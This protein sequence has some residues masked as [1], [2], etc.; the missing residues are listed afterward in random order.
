MGGGGVGLTGQRVRGVDRD[1]NRSG[2]VKRAGRGRGLHLGR[3]PLLAIQQAG[4]RNG[5]YQSGRCW[6]KADVANLLFT[7]QHLG[8]SSLVALLHSWPLTKYT[9]MHMVT[10]VTLA[11]HQSSYAVWP[12]LMCRQGLS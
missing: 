11:R 10:S 5:K 2:R 12:C 8:L 3:D 6:I 1:A 9:V 7:L 4:E